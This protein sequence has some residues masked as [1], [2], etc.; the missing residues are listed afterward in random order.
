MLTITVDAAAGDPRVAQ[1]VRLTK[2]CNKSAEVRICAPQKLCH[3]P[4]GMFVALEGTE[5]APAS[6]ILIAPGWAAPRLAKQSDAQMVITYGMDGRDTL[7]P[8]SVLHEGGMAAL[9]REIVD[10]CGGV[11]SP[12]EIDLTPLCG[13]LMDKM[14]VAAAALAAGLYGEWKKLL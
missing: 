9:Q 12:C 8:S 13:T 2:S 4:D 5:Y 6:R 3:A 1:L 7:T 14:A 11:I 10:V